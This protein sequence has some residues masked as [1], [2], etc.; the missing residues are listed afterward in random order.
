MNNLNEVDIMNYKNF[1]S[2]LVKQTVEINDVKC[3][4]VGVGAKAFKIGFKA[5]NGFSTNPKGELATFFINVNQMSPEFKAQVDAF[6]PQDEQEDDK[7]DFL[8]ML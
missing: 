2:Q 1:K 3:V 6:L 4:I 5:P 7:D 8:D